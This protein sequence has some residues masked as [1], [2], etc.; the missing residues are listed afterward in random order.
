MKISIKR[1][2]EKSSINTIHYLLVQ[3]QDKCCHRLFRKFFTDRTCYRQTLLHSEDFYTQT[4]S[5]TKAF[6]LRTEAFTPRSFAHS[7]ASTLMLLHTDI[8][9][10]GFTHRRFYTPTLLHID[11]LT[12]RSLYKET[13][14]HIDAF[15]PNPFTHRC[16]YTKNTFTHR[17]FLYRRFYTQKL[18]H[19]NTF[20]HAEAFTH[21]RFYAQKLFTHIPFYTHFAGQRANRNLP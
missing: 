4:L 15:T 9:T 2:N 18:W 6:T 8:F 3:L 10:H 11:A 17:D 13:L 20:T 19:R 7:C 14:L 21:R 12:H 1:A 5:H 16:F